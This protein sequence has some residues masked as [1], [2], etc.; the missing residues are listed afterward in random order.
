MAT[1]CAECTYT[2]NST[3]LYPSSKNHSLY[4]V[5]AGEVQAYQQNDCTTFTLQVLSK[6]SSFNNLAFFQGNLPSFGIKSIG[7][8]RIL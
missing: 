7:Y 5:L 2:P 1:L 8:S 3:I 4:F 6:G